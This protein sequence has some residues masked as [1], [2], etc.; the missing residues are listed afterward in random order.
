[1]FTVE[2]L[3]RLDPG[4]WTH[5]LAGAL[6]T[7]GLVVTD[8]A[9]EPCSPAR[10]VLRYMVTLYGHSD[11]IT[12]IGKKTGAVEARFYQ[13]VAPIL[14]SLTARCWRRRLEGDHSWLLLD[15]IHNDYSQEQWTVKDVERVIGQMAT[16]HA[17][18]WQ[19]AAIWADEAYF[20]YF[21]GPPSYNKP[22]SDNGRPDNHRNSY[23][24]T[25]DDGHENSDFHEYGAY[26][27]DERQSSLVSEHALKHSGRLAP[28]LQQAASGLGRLRAIGGWP[29]V[30]DEQQ[31]TAA[32]DLIDDPLPMTLT[33]QQLSPAL[34]HGDMA[35]SHWRL[36]LFNEQ[37]LLDWQNC[38]VGA[39]VYDLVSFVEQFGLVQDKSGRSGLRQ[40]WPINEETMV[41]SYLL[42][43]SS[44]LGARFNARA[45]RQ[46]IP[47]AR[48]LYI[49]TTW[50]PRFATWLPP[51][52]DEAASVTAVRRGKQRQHLAEARL[53]QMVGL[54]PYL[55]GVFKRF[56]GAYK[57]L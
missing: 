52:P 3:Q 26:L 53:A 55:A 41:D 33:L 5:L 11:P 23:G 56:L 2:E 20:P 28:L 40:Q 6:E 36:T 21:I 46:A 25:K 37:R 24:H 19:Q 18:T 4:A 45:V 43:M 13:E 27:L 10:N 9:S 57:L 42:H 16:L 49:L 54:Q 32:A 35:P 29:G 44:A 51:S 15:E 22:R 1:M 47:A 39:A 30:L 50:L 31:M 14:P 8:V 12:F 38:A 7:P 34:I 48:C 17:T